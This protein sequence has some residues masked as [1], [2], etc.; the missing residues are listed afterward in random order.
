[1][2][3]DHVAFGLQAERSLPRLVGTAGPILG[4]ADTADDAA[5]RLAALTASPKMGR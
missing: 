2:H 3:G 1:M 5:Q 4:D